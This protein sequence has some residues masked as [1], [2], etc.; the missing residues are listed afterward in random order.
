MPI[1]SFSDLRAQGRS[2]SKE[3]RNATG[4]GTTSRA[5]SP[6]SRS[7][8]PTNSGG[9][10]VPL[11]SGRPPAPQIRPMQPQMRAADDFA[12]LTASLL[13]RPPTP[14]RSQPSSHR[15]RSRTGDTHPRGGG[16]SPRRKDAG[17]QCDNMNASSL[18]STR[19][20]SSDNGFRPRTPPRGRILP[21]DTSAPITPMKLSAGAYQGV[22]DASQ[23]ARAPS[24]SKSRRS[25]SPMG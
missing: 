15:N 24:P 19:H 18:A 10:G 21:L 22:T 4:S 25:Q 13:P 16:V 1:T 6:Q 9:V 5:A 17:T 3:R 12:M 14:P 23:H 7:T 8:T 2:S 11:G 20:A